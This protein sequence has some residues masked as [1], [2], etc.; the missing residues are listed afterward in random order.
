MAVTERWPK[1]KKKKRAFQRSR[2]TKVRRVCVCVSVAVVRGCER[3]T[4]FLVAHLARWR[5]GPAV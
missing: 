5:E 4:R 3:Q 2:F 1:K